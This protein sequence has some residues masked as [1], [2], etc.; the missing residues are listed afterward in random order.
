MGELVTLRRRDQKN[1]CRLFGRWAKAVRGGGVE[2]DGV[3]RV[4]IE[5]LTSQCEGDRAFDDL[6]P[7]LPVMGD[8]SRFRLC[9]S[10]LDDSQT[11]AGSTQHGVCAVGAFVYGTGPCAY[12]V[13]RRFTVLLDELA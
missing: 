10:H 4:E 5:L 13:V 9:N 12:E 1:A 7:L 6:Q 3:S 11:C 8:R 2:L